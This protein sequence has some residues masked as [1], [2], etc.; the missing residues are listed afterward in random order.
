MTD[1]DLPLRCQVG[2]CDNRATL[3][4]TVEL[5]IEWSES[6]TYSVVTLQVTACGDCAAQLES[7]GHGLLH[8]RV[9]FARQQEI[10]AHAGRLA[11]ELVA[12]IEA[13]GPPFEP[14]HGSVFA[15]WLAKLDKPLAQGAWRL[16]AHIK[17]Q[18]IDSRTVRRSGLV[19]DN[20]SAYEGRTAS[21]PASIDDARY[22]R[23][24]LTQPSQQP[25]DGGN[26]AA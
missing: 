19:F 5:P 17:R 13:V 24:A 8:A 26:D 22:R 3:T 23:H 14:V 18:H 16:L 10:E 15:T 4:V 12:L 20:D 9:R 21:R 11:T 6:R 2:D 7:L 1:T 25:P